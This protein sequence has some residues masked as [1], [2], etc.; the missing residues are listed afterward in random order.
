MPKPSPEEDKKPVARPRRRWPAILALVVTVL[1]LG[2]AALAGSAG[3]TTWRALQ[4]SEL[5]EALARDKAAQSIEA[6]A[7]FRHTLADVLLQTARGLREVEVGD[8]Q[9]L[10]GMFLS[11]SESIKT[12]ALARGVSGATME[13]ADTLLREMAETLLDAGETEAAQELSGDA[14]DIAEKRLEAD[15]SPQAQVGL[16]RAT[17]LSGRVARAAGNVEAARS[18][19]EEARTILVELLRD[20]PDDAPAKAALAA[21]LLPLSQVLNDQGEPDA[22]MQMARSATGLWQAAL[23]APDADPA[24]H[25]TA[26]ATLEQLAS[27]QVDNGD[28]KGARDTAAQAV[29]ARRAVAEARPKS[30]EAK[31]ALASALLTEGRADLAAGRPEDARKVLWEGYSL[32]RSLGPGAAGDGTEM[33]QTLETLA[34]AGGQ[35]GDSAVAVQFLREA[36]RLRRQAVEL[37]A[38]DRGAKL[39]LAR[40][41]DALG[42]ART[43]TG[44]LGAALDA[45]EESLRLLRSL[46][47]EESED[48][49]LRDAYADTWQSIG[50]TRL[51]EGDAQAA[52]GFFNTIV[53]VRRDLAKAAP[54]DVSRQAALASILEDIGDASREAE[55]Q[56]AARAAYEEAVTI[57]RKLAQPDDA[58][59]RR[60]LAHTLLKLGDLELK[61]GDREAARPLYGEAADLA[62]A[63]MSNGQRSA[64]FVRE[65]ADAI[66]RLGD[67]ALRDGAPDGAVTDYRQA[68]AMRQELADADASS[69]SLPIVL[70]R[71]HARIGDAL[72]ASGDGKAA[73]EAYAR[74]ADPLRERAADE[75]EGTRSARQLGLCLYKLAVVSDGDAREAARA[76][77]Q[78]VLEPLDS[79]GALSAETKNEIEELKS[80]LSAS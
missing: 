51:E 26:A 5:R 64:A 16:A 9:A 47:A 40:A 20:R 1:A 53:D 57:R 62:Q 3:L 19:L 33:M 27:W 59:S 63:L 55:N 46:G 44:A 35:A 80:S 15:P 6:Q 37:D 52:L 38:G 23:A 10:A 4:M 42:D 14:A 34:E 54:D 30:R 17:A 31:I 70:A 2:I 49:E 68:L 22:A 79:V 29:A 41:L 71:T 39:R 48:P 61:L 74:C 69:A 50:E 24:W 75:E 77:A 58:P 12:S 13:T 11:V 45:Y 8:P 78:R 43:D 66:E 56:D 72:R 67:L 21:L 32:Q 25:R 7:A 73:A 36:V 76:E 28:L 60:H 18:R 65:A